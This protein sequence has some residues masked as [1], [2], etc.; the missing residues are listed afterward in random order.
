M[1][2]YNPIE[3]RPQDFIYS[4]YSELSGIDI[5]KV[6][7]PFLMA[8]RPVILDYEETEYTLLLFRVKV[9]PY[10]YKGLINELT[11]HLPLEY[12][13]NMV[14]FKGLTPFY[15]EVLNILQHWW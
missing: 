7:L 8:G 10:F 15:L 13:E 11:K 9:T 4:I 1:K 14:R 12:V 3:I 5:A 6:I 2:L